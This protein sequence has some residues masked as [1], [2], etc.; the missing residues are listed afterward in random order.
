MS[1]KTPRFFS[2]GQVAP[3]RAK[4]LDKFA[5][6]LQ[7]YYKQKYKKTSKKLQILFIGAAE[8][9]SGLNLNSAGFGSYSADTEFGG[10]KS[11]SEGAKILIKSME[12]QNVI[13]NYLVTLRPHPLDKHFKFDHSIQ[14]QHPR[15]NTKIDSK[16][17]IRR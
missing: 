16:T 13:N 12:N 15:Q 2:R 4:K 5:S 9:S 6:D 7:H 3:F 8:E 14:D 11:S 17:C 10:L 1:L